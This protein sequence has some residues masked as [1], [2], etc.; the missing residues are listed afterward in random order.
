[1]SIVIKLST[2]VLNFSI[3]SIVS[4]YDLIRLLNVFKL[5][6]TLLT[7][8]ELQFLHFKVSSFVKTKLQL[9]HIFLLLILIHAFL[10]SISNITINF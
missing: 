8:L 10:S 6:S 7:K 4:L 2:C 9:V 3:T 1:M 5:S